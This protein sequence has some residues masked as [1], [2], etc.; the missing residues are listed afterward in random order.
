MAYCE[1]Y[2]A[3]HAT[4]AEEGEAKTWKFQKAKQNWLVK[5]FWDDAEVGTIAEVFKE[6]S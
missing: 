6:A 1:Q 5:H 4:T 3:S 2:I